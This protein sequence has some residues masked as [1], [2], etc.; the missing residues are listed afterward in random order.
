[1]RFQ[2]SSGCSV[3]GKHFLRFQG[4]AAVYKSRYLFT[5]VIG[6][7]SFNAVTVVWGLELWKQRQRDVQ[8]SVEGML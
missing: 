4:D 3:D 2:I 1:M 5:Y 8:V 7:R 6:T